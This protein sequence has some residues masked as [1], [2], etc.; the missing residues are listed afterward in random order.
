M[1]IQ[2]EWEMTNPLFNWFEGSVLFIRPFF[3]TSSEESMKSFPIAL[4]C[5]VIEMFE[6]LL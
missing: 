3:S 5:N 1:T 4:E 2:F 6:F